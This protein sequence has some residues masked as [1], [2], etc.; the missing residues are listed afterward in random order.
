MSSSPPMMR[1]G[2]EMVCLE[3]VEG[4]VVNAGGGLALESVEGLWA[5]VGGRCLAPF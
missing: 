2:T 1:V 4:V 3:K 5:L